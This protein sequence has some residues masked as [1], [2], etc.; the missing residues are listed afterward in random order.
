MATDTTQSATI[1]IT[2]RGMVSSLGSDVITACAAARAGLVL[3][4]PLD[5][6]VSSPDDGRPEAIAGHPAGEMTRGFEGFARLVRLAALGLG[7]L[8]RQ[9]P[10]GPWL[11]ART[12]VYLALPDPHR[13]H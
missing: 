1:A 9:A 2:A 6:Q 3:P 11:S 10:D 4:A 12:G 7:D 5:F 8:L 13:V